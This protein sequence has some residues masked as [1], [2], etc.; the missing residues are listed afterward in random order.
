MREF[1]S[2]YSA[3]DKSFIKAV[4][5]SLLLYL[6]NLLFIHRGL[7]WPLGLLYLPVLVFLHIKMQGR[8]VPRW[9]IPVLLIPFSL[10]CVYYVYVR[11]VDKI[12]PVGMNTYQ[13]SYYLSIIVLY[14][15]L[16]LYILFNRKSWLQPVD[17]AKARLIILFC[18]KVLMDCLSLSLYLFCF[19]GTNYCFVDDTL[20]L[21]TISLLMLFS[22][23][24]MG[25]Y[26]FIALKNNSNLPERT[27]EDEF[28]ARRSYLSPEIL[29]EYEWRLKNVMEAEQLYLREDMS[30]ELLVNATNIPRHH[31]S[32]LFNNHLQVSF[33][34]FIAEYRI[35]YA[36][37]SLKKEGYGLTLEGLASEC[38]FN[39]KTTFNKYFKEIT[40]LSLYEYRHRM[41]R[42]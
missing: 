30:I 42:P 29:S 10:L 33:F 28:K 35:S 17:W 40:G 21:R 26:L 25:H 15:Y 24:L 5:I 11:Y 4:F 23:I 27:D 34:R 18:V 38:G 32:E 19:L 13:L 39:S 12:A 8:H 31:L 1:L 41:E 2:G 7:A 37:E 16:C 14:T 20:C 9:L 36:I 6:L 22:L 3:M